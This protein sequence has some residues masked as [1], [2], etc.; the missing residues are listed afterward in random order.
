MAEAAAS[1]TMKPLPQ[2]GA[3]TAYFCSICD[4]H[5]YSPKIS[6]DVR[7]YAVKRSIT[8]EDALVKGIAVKSKG[9]A[10]AG[11]EVYVLG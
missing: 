11:A 1:S 7:Q 6:K 10:E 8:E 3:K 5:F 9:F 2:D 4:L